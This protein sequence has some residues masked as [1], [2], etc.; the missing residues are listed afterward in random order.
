MRPRFVV[1]TPVALLSRFPLTSYFII[2]LV[3]SWAVVLIVLLGYL[4][5][6]FLAIDRFIAE[7]GKGPYPD[8]E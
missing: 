7:H 2:A 4:P 1:P 6:N 3:F 8:M 5:E